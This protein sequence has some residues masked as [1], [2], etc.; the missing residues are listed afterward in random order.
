MAAAAAVLL[1]LAAVFAGRE[2]RVASEQKGLADKQTAEAN[3]Q[4]ATAEAQTA[5]AKKQ[6]ALA[7]ERRAAALQDESA[8][9]TALSNASRSASP[10][11][12]TKLALA[13]WPRNL[14][15]H[16]PKLD[17]ALA[18]L[19]AAV[20][21]LR[22]RKVLRGHDGG[23]QSAAFSPDGARV[24]TASEDKTA[25]VWDAATGKPVAVLSGHDGPV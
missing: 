13:A 2:A 14:V 25:R 6:K 16:R 12:A 7:D 17:V 20:L 3:R 5:E 10:A 18:A 8:A 23:V 11:L 4:K 22:E 24:V 15:D 9:L 21:D 1:L 19:S